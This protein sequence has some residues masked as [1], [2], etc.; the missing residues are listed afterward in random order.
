MLAPNLLRGIQVAAKRR[1]AAG[2]QYWREHAVTR[3]GIGVQQAVRIRN[4]PAD[5]RL[6]QHAFNAFHV[7]ALRQ[8]DAARVAAKTT[9]IMIPRDENLRA[10]TRRMIRQ[11]RQQCV[12]GRAGDDF[13]PARVLKFREGRHQVF[14]ARKIEIAG[15]QKPPMIQLRE[16]VERLVPMRAMRFFLRQI[17]QPVEV[18]DV[19]V[20]QQRID[21]HRAQRRCERECQARVHAVP[22]PAFHHL[23]QR[24]VG[25][26]DGFEQPGFL[27]KFLV[28]RMPD[29][30][31]M[32][33]EDEG[34][35][36][37]HEGL[38]EHRTLNAER[39]KCLVE[40]FEVL[41]RPYRAEGHWSTR[42]RAFSPGYKM[43]G[44]QP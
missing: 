3:F 37:L 14:F 7:C 34:E 40:T 27:Q 43:T 25:F 10:Q 18:P 6:L 15:L 1:H 9:A 22:F 44:L 35:I 5:I 24:D 42:T 17:N 41:L 21:Q 19:A 2:R 13:Q 30:R 16:L 20:L 12:R 36:S 4:R 29:E 33:V 39:R 26:R 28:L 8:P 11:Q 38:G 23:Q 31:Q 32:R